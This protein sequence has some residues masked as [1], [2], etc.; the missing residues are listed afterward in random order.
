MGWRIQISMGSKCISNSGGNF[1][2]L[3]FVLPL[4]VNFCSIL[5]PIL[6]IKRKIES[7]VIFISEI[8]EMGW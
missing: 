4:Q 2:F 7:F 3:V 6:K 8:L 5:L 1:Q